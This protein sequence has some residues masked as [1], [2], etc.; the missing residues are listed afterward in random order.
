MD[1]TISYAD[2]IKIKM[3][4][5][6]IIEIKD[7]KEAIKPAYKLWIDFGPHGILKSSAQITKNYSK[8]ALLGKQIIAVANFPV[9]QIGPFQ[10]ECLVLGIE[11]E[12][13]DVILLSMG[14]KTSNGL[15]I[16]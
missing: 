4:T 7:F 13:G 6:T 16:S 2:F 1:Q 11:R 10:S 15:N 14:E 8:E 9:K 12:P 5:G 3:I